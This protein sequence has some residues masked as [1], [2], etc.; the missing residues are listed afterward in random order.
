MKVSVVMPCFNEIRTI[1]TI[2]KGKGA[3]LRTGFAHAT[4][5]IIIIQD[6]DLEYDPN[7]YPKLLKPKEDGF[8]F[9]PVYSEG[10][11]PWL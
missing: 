2:I 6:A 7:E 9:E 8:G 11:T 1:E 5:D 10:S 4:G 3:A